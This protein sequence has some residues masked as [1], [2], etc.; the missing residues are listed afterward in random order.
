ME[1]EVIRSYYAGGTN[2]CLL[3]AG[4]LICFT[5]ELPWKENAAGRSCIPEGRYRLR[6]RWS[7]RFGRHWQLVAVPGRDLILLHAANNAQTELRGC[8][9]PVSLVTAPGCGLSSRKALYRL[10]QLLEARKEETHFITFKS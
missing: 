6:R 8:I 4:E 1:L 2:G 10:H 9:A 3:A 7:R 5:I